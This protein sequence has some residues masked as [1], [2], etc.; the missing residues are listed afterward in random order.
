MHFNDFHIIGNHNN[1]YPID[2]YRHLNFENI[3]LR[4]P[5]CGRG[6]FI[7]INKTYSLEKYYLMT[8]IYTFLLANFFPTDYMVVIALPIGIYTYPLV[9]PV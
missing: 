5:V 6:A 3:P 8:Y 9:L 2:L 7:R 4:I 1:D